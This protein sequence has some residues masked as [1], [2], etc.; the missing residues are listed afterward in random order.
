MF[1]SYN[2]IDLAFDCVLHNL[3]DHFA[4]EHIM[5]QLYYESLYDFSFYFRKLLNNYNSAVKH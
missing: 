5:N 3:Y 1:S 2:Y 4:I